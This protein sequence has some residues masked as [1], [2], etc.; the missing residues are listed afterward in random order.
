[1]NTQPKASFHTG[2]EGWSGDIKEASEPHTWP[3]LSVTYE[4]IL[5]EFFGLRPAP[6]C[7]FCRGDCSQREY[8]PC[9][10]LGAWH[11]AGS[12]CTGLFLY[13]GAH[14]PGS[15][16]H[17]LCF[18]TAL[19]GHP[20]SFLDLDGVSSPHSTVQCSYITHTSCLHSLHTWSY[21]VLHFSVSLL[22]KLPLIMFIQ[23]SKR[24]S[25]Q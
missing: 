17:T 6:S 10:E 21:K 12:Q 11:T 14:Q 24:R 18:N 2:E 16:H 5:G 13:H 7:L 4:W 19:Q 25:W 3:P 1:M 15:P 9:T 22:R 8:T 20:F 23:L